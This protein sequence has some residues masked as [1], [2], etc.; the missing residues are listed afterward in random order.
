RTL[1]HAPHT[2]CTSAH[3]AIWRRFTR[4]RTPLSFPT[5]RSSDLFYAGRVPPTPGDEALVKKL[6]ARLQADRL[7]ADL[8]IARF[9][10]DSLE[11]RSEEHTSELQ[12][13]LNLVCRLL[14]EKKKIDAPITEEVGE[15]SR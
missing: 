5:R 6:V 13:H 11:A 7:R 9:K 2:S 15:Q 14:L 10:Q 1:P 12:S 8:G 4:H 3:D